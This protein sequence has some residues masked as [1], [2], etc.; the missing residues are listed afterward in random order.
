LTLNSKIL[1]IFI[2]MLVISNLFFLFLAVRYRSIV[3]E[4]NKKY[5]ETP[6]LPRYKNTNNEFK[7]LQKNSHHYDHTTLFIGSS[8]IENW[9]FEK[10][11]EDK[12]FINRGV[13]KGLKR[14]LLT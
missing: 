2:V 7:I 3:V 9:N 11:F 6:S 14:M 5:M 4:R 1:I 13:G 8:I 12:A 10:Y